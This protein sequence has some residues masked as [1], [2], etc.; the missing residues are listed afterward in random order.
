M[1]RLKRYWFP[2]T[3]A[4][5]L[6]ASELL[7]AWLLAYGQPT[8]TRWLGDTLQNSSDVAV[9]LSYIRQGTWLL[10]NPFAV[11]PHV[12]RFDLVWSALSA[13]HG[14]TKLSPLLL[15]EI[16]RWAATV[17]L[18]VSVHA[19]ARS[20]ARDEREARLASLLAIGGIGLGWLYSAT[21]GA[22]NS[23][24]WRTDGAP[25]IVSEF[26]V[27]PTLFGGAHMILSI[28]L[29]IY[30][31]RGLWEVIEQ[32]H[33]RIWTVML[34]IA[35]LTSFHPYFI[36]L[37]AAVLFV[38][39]AKRVRDP[40]HHSG[41]IARP[42]L[43][44]ASFLPSLAYYLWL[45][46][47]PVFR[48]HYL[49]TNVLPLASLDRWV[50]V[51]LPAA[52]A[53][54]WIAMQHDRRRMFLKQ[55]RWCQAWLVAA[56]IL[57]LF[58]PV[59]WS[60]KLTEGLMIPLVYLTVPAWSAIAASLPKLARSLFIGGVA[61]ASALHLF[62]SQAAWLVAP[63]NARWFNQPDA[64]FQAWSF[65]ESRSNAVVVSDDMWTN[66]WTPAW[67]GK[68]VWIGHSHE[69]PDYAHKLAVWRELFATHDRET[70]RFTLQ[71]VPTTHL[72]LT[73]KESGERMLS[74]LPPGEW[75]VAFQAEEV[76]VLERIQN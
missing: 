36:P 40:A 10:R 60:R 71:T 76:M 11:E 50:F 3:L 21:L 39:W 70:V 69:T 35:A 6:I 5:G 73:S 18:A 7:F 74:L 68:I 37:I 46:S 59:P 33:R 54:A 26:A 22:T 9:Y 2:L 23:W 55:T 45:L 42:L 8:G 13:V 43:L 64:V 72:L 28:A 75:T 58:L 52:I 24:T 4:L 57:A 41:I 66:M 47:D 62:A 25:D 48:V 27:V 31:M 61:G 49:Q 17:A 15:H 67:T 53:F 32:P 16:A 56:T 1:K 20:V 14:W 19:A 51:L 30:V 38:A 34:A 12:L 44:A 65:L 63:E 29:L